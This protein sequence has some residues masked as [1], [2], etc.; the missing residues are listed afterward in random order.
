MGKSRVNEGDWFEGDWF[1][2]KKSFIESE[3]IKPGSFRP[4]EEGLDS[5]E[6]ELLRTRKT[7]EEFYADS[8][9]SFSDTLT[10]VYEFYQKEFGTPGRVYYPGCDMDSTPIRAFP[11]SD[12]TLLD[13][14]EHAIKALQRNGIEAIHGD[15]KLYRPDNLHDLLILLNPGIKSRDATPTLKVGGYVIANDWHGNTTELLTIPEEFNFIGILNENEDKQL[16]LLSDEVSREILEKA[17]PNCFQ[18]Y[19]AFFEKKG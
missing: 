8:E 3:D 10:K 2:K 6:L 15:A 18:N 16:R 5:M 13:I 4:L 9:P 7:T 12:V 19:Y 1:E 17:G 11:N 14:N